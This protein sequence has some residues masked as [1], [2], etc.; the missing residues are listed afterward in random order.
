MSWNSWMFSVE[1]SAPGELQLVEE[2]GPKA[3]KRATIASVVFIALV[4]AGLLWFINRFRERG[5]FAG[6]LWRPFRNIEIW[7]FLIYKW[8]NEGGE[9]PSLWYK[10]TNAGGLAATFR[11]AIVA[12]ILCLILGT[13]TAVWRSKRERPRGR[14]V[15]LAVVLFVLFLA[16]IAASISNRWAALG[17]LGVAVV[18]ALG[19][20]FAGF[21]VARPFATLYVEGFRACA[22]VLLMKFGFLMYPRVFPGLAINTYAYLS[23]VTGLTLYYSTVFSEVVRSG[24]RSI[25]NGQTEA[26]LAIGLPEKRAMNLV[27]LP[28]A[29]RKALPN[30]VTQSASLLKDTSLGLLITYA[31]LTKQAQIS[32]EFGE[33]N[34]QTFIVAGA[35]YISI[36]ALITSFA[37][38]L[39]KKQK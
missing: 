20:R 12:L 10:I 35:M 4:A 11:A 5:Q 26:A 17:V 19:S 21:Q 27:V 36:I 22:L 34:L 18:L 13:V 15:S 2:L 1:P 30:L 16:V 31:E 38:R 8:G 39:K 25:S 23:V 9:N 24:I 32:G 7:K 14:E 6:A 3:R 29:L 33:N 28:Q 37:N